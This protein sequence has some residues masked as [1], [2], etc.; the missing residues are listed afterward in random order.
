VD[1]M[2]ISIQA[3]AMLSSISGNEQYRILSLHII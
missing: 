3:V 2:Q 1:Y